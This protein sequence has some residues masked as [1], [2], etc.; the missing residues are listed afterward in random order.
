M[1]DAKGIGCTETGDFLDDPTC[2]KG[3]SATVVWIH[4]LFEPKGFW[5]GV[6]DRDV[7]PWLEC[8][9]PLP[10]PLLGNPRRFDWALARLLGQLP[11]WATC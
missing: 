1:G 11:C 8:E 7:G 9:L 10:R 6:L 5:G 4:D 2:G 3:S